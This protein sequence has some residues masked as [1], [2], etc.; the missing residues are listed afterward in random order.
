MIEY[1]SIGDD[2][3]LEELGH[4]LRQRRI[5]KGLTQAELAREAGVSKRTV[6]RIEAGAAAQTLNLVRILRVLELLGG[7]DQ[8]V[9]EAGPSPLDLLKRKGKARKRATSRRTA[10]SPRDNWS[11]GDDA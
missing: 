1:V 4:R 11:W 3:I 7:I 8:L 10:T 6:E 5:T 9:P 2:A